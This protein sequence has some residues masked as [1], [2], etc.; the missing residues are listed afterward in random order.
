MKT[1]EAI[2]DKFK[3]FN[4]VG[5]TNLAYRFR[6]RVSTDIDFFAGKPISFNEMETIYKDL[7]GT[8][9]AD[10]K[11]MSKEKVFDHFSYMTGKFGL[12]VKIDVSQNHYFLNLPI[13]KDGINF[14]SVEDIGMLKIESMVGRGSTK[15][16][17]DLDFITDKNGG[18][19]DVIDLWNLYK[20]KREFLSKDYRKIPFDIYKIRDPLKRP[21]ELKNI[22]NEDWIFPV[23]WKDEEDALKSWELKVNTLLLYLN[24]EQGNHY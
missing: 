1:L 22:R 8:Y 23:E 3:V 5:G 17:Y 16:A 14:S 11:P 15:D 12:P 7:I 2:K 10:L 4:L 13:L 9:G 18:N 6:H 21:E 24:K 19:I 20:K